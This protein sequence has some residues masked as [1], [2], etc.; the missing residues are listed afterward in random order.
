MDKFWEIY[1]KEKNEYIVGPFSVNFVRSSYGD[2]DFGVIEN[3]T[4]ITDKYQ[5]GIKWKSD[6]NLCGWKIQLENG[7]ICTDLRQIDGKRPFY[8]IVEY[9][10]NIIDKKILNVKVGIK[11]MNASGN[12]DQLVG[13]YNYREYK[14]YGVPGWVL[15]WYMDNCHMEKQE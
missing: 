7:T 1:N 8:I 11:Y 12:Y 13:E 3:M 6:S 9:D 15:Y 10:K 4:L 2:I 5:N 14:V